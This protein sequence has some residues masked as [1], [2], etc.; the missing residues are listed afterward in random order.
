MQSKAAM[1]SK[2]FINESL[3]PSKIY[4]GFNNGSDNKKFTIKQN[5]DLVRAKEKAMMNFSSGVSTPKSHIF[6][7]INDGRKKSLELSIKL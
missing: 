7:Q 1:N 3:S 2:N 6:N 4:P 5:P